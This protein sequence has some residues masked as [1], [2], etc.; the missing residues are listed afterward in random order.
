VNDLRHSYHID[1]RKEKG[2]PSFVVSPVVIEDDV[3][4]GYNATIMKG[5]TIGRGAIIQPGSMILKD[6]PPGAVVSGNPARIEQ[7]EYA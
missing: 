5:V 4:I 2:R 1:S 3:W 7:K 6:V